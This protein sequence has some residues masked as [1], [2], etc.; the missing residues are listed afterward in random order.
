MGKKERG[1]AAISAVTFDILCLMK[2]KL[3]MDTVGEVSV[4]VCISPLVGAKFTDSWRL[5]WGEE[6]AAQGTR[7]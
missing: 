5:G 3:H 1:Q 4:K 2:R 7:T 6:R